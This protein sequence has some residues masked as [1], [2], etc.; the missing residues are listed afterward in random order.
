MYQFSRSLYRELAPEVV[1]RQGR[2]RLC[3]T[4]HA[5]PSRVRGLDGTPRPEIGT[6]SRSRSRRS[7]TTCG[8][9]FPMTT[10][11]RLPDVRA[12]H[13]A[14]H[15]V[16]RQ[17]A[18]RGRD[19]RRQ[20]G[21]AATRARAGARRASACRCRAASTARRTSTSTRFRGRRRLDGLTPL[22]STAD[23]PRGGR[24]RH[25][26]RRRAARRRPARHRPSRR[27]R[28][29]D[30]S[31]GVMAAVERGARRAGAE[32]GDVER[33]VH[34]MTVGTNALLEGRVARTALLATEG[35]TDLEELG[36]QARAELY[37]LCAGHP[38]PLVPAGAARRGARAHRPRRRAARAR[39]GRAAR[40]RSRALDVRGGRRL[41][42]VGLPPPG[43]RARASPS[44][45]RRAARRARVD[46]AR[47][48]RRVPR[49]RA[50]RDDD[51]RR[52]PLAA[53]ARLPRAARRAR[54]ATPACPSPRSCCRAAASPSAGHAPRATARW[55]VLSGPA[56]GAVGAA[57]M[58]ER[59][60]ERTR[61]ASTW[62]A[63]RATCRVVA[64]RRG[65][66]A[67]GRERRRP[68]AGA[69][70]GRRAHGRRR[71]RHRSPGAT[72]AAR[73]AWARARRAPTPARPATAAAASEPTVTDAEPA[74]RLPRRRLA[75]GGRR[76]ARPRRR[77]AGASARLADELGLSSTRPPPASRAWPSAEMARAVRVMTVERGIDPRE[78]ALRR[79]RRRGAAARRRDRRRARHAPGARAARLGRAVGARAD[80]RRAPPRPRRERA[81]RRRRRSRARPS[82]EVVERLAERGARRSSARAEAELRA[83]YDLRYA[84]QAFELTIDGD[85][86]ARPERAARGVR[87]APT[88]SATATRTP[89]P[90]SSSSRCAWPRRCRA[91]SRPSAAG[92]PRE[93][94]GARDA[95]FGGERHERDG[96]SAAARPSVDGPAIFELPEATLVV[97]PGWRARAGRR[98]RL[99]MER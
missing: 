43:A 67:G 59:R 35:F 60:R 74:A 93:R 73:C 42:A 88:R 64:R 48:R 38:P 61:S 39:R 80:R 56:G 32:P 83:T 96:R 41:P 29:R 90:S 46:L 85:A 87:R 6:T 37:R 99:V 11:A 1:R 89:T 47:D 72:R 68:R 78:L 95:R 75:A 84:G 31:E 79:L 58:A 26:H 77:R 2:G 40:A 52:R 36:R 91:P 81:A 44:W 45:P 57:R 54:R 12:A 10:A 30:Q 86:R 92:A 14:G 28:P 51:R 7:S 55:T 24:R 25:L 22:A 21:S 15:R 98:R 70:D 20:P 97:P 3:K 5:V 76:R 62:A 18:A 66:E 13:G 49:V 69:A 71:R 23:D 34:G 65:R 8:I 50:L 16:R 4:A 53:A 19:L 63:R 17:P 27:P 9:Y 82:R 94:R 33:F